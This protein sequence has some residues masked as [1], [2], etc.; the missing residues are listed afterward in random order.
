MGFPKFDPWQQKI[1]KSDLKINLGLSNYFVNLEDDILPQK[2]FVTSILEFIEEQNKI[3]DWS[4]LLLS[5]W[6][7]G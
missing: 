3:G 5:R 6:A 2:H 1:A 4:S 7:P